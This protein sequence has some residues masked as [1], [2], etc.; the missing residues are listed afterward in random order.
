[1]SLPVISPQDAKL[2]LE[3]GALLIDI[4]DADEHGRE[5][6]PNGKNVPIS[7][8]CDTQVG[9]GHDAI[10]YY[11][12]T[13][14]RTK[15]NAQLLMEAAKTEAF[16]LEGGI[17]NWKKT[18]MA[19]NKRAGAPIEMMRQVQIVAGGFVVIGAAL[20]FLIS[21]AFY[22][23]SGAVGAGLIFSGISGT[24]A[25]AGVLKIMPWNRTAA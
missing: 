6:I 18:G 2:L 4:R 15:M 3:K 7:K 19:V 21:P 23:L 1:M 9:E 22:A 16:I 12:K 14:N 11:C 24:C 5:H 10:V 25:M 8:L 17:E 13:G 20:G